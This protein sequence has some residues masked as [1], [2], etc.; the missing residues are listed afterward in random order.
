[1]MVQQLQQANIKHIS[2]IGLII[3]LRLRFSYQGE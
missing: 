1:M 2:G 3:N